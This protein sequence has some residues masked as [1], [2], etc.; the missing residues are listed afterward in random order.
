MRTMIDSLF[1]IE[2]I[3]LWISERIALLPAFISS[4]GICQYLLTCDFLAL[5]QP[6]QP[7]RY[8][9]QALVALLYVLQSA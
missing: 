3:I 5:Q 4:A 6:F 2:L 7:Q 1:Q 8:S 9:I